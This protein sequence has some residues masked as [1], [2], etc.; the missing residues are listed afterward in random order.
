V[1]CFG[2]SAGALADLRRKV[3]QNRRHFVQR[4][5]GLQSVLT[6]RQL[7]PLLHDLVVDRQNPALDRLLASGL[8][9]QIHEKLIIAFEGLVQMLER[10]RLSLGLE[11]GANLREAEA[12]RGSDLESVFGAALLDE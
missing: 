2:L 3:A 8:A 7:V 6:A 9:E 1:G 4:H 12:Y 10:H 5:L 11:S